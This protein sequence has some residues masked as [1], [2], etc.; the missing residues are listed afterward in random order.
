M[1]LE[2]VANAAAVMASDNASGIMG[3]TVNLTMGGVAD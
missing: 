3:T 2:E 1:A